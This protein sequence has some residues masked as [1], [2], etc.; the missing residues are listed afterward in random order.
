MSERRKEYENSIPSRFDGTCKVC[1]KPYTVGELISP[2]F[3]HDYKLWRHTSCFQFFYLPLQYGNDCQICK[4]EIPIGTWGYWSKHNGIWCVK[5]GEKEFP[6]V[7]V[8]YSRHRYEFLNEN[9]KDA[10]FLSRIKKRR[11]E[12]KFNEDEAP[13]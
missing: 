9:T 3:D 8:A 4:K 2:Y 12:E 11:E 5:C 6:T 7:R 1:G 10:S 13:F